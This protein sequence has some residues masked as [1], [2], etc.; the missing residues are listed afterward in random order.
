LIGADMPRREHVLGN[1]GGGHGIPPA[2]IESQ[3]G[4]DLG[5]LARRHVIV[6]GQPQIE[7]HLDGLIAGDQRRQGYDASISG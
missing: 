6:E 2:G 1:S 3:M 4:D 7:R 5:K